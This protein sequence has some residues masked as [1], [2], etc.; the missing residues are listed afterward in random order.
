MCIGIHHAAVRRQMYFFP[1]M[2]YLV[3]GSPYL[4]FKALCTQHTYTSMHVHVY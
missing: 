1:A 3:G 2:V 4:L